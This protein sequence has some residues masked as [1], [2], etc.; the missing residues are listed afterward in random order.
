M[1]R[2]PGRRQ[3]NRNIGTVARSEGIAFI[4]ISMGDRDP[5]SRWFMKQPD[6]RLGQP[7]R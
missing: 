3:Q 5:S 1:A 4:A 6:S 2:R 7:R